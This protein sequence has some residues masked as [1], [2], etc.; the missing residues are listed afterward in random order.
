[1]SLL[2]AVL[3]LLSLALTLWQFGAAMRFPLHR[4]GP[5]THTPPVTLLKPL[6]G[7]DAETEACL[8]SWF[9]QNYAG[10]IQIL[11]GVASAEDPVC[12]IVRKL[13][14]AHPDVHAQLVICP[15]SL[16]ANAKVSKLAQLARLARH[17]VLVVSDADVR[18]PADLLGQLVAPLRESNVGLASCLY[19]LAQP[20]NLAMRWE[21]FGTNADFWSQ[22][23]QAQ[24]L[25]P[26]DF[27]LGAAMALP[28]SEL[29]VLGGFEAFVDH[30][31]D[32][33]QLGNRITQRGRRIVLCPVVVECWSAPLSWSE[34]WRHQLRWA[35]TIRVCRPSAYFFSI[36]ANGTLWPLLWI[37]VLPAPAVLAAAAGCL[38]VRMLTA[39][40]LEQRIN[41]KLD[42]NSLGLAPAKDLVQVVVWTMAFAGNHV[43]WRG[44]RLRVRR[45]G[46]VE[47]A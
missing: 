14:D 45:G 34:A 11:F 18:V 33:Y 29:A 43:V 6:K 1:M 37:T 26:L 24:T 32:D 16:G 47:R 4:R 44:L 25:G 22:V 3:A 31:A 42:L 12:D 30:L 23:L 41:R 46:T 9:T 8:R 10:R 39:V 28:R 5:A 27:A 19:R 40:W 21:A 15:E 7:C 20:A 36:L 38:L 13:I 2:L 35:R 17:E